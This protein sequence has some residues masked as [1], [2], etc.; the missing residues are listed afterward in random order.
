MKAD[1]DNTGRKRTFR[2]IVLK[3]KD[4]ADFGASELQGIK[5]VVM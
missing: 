5:S 2:S 3:V 1:V 4:I